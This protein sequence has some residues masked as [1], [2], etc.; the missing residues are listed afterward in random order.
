MELQVQ[1]A[2]A[3]CEKATKPSFGGME[4]IKEDYILSEIKFLHK[5]QMITKIE[6]RKK[7][8]LFFWWKYLDY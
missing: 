1:G 2:R 4:S 5:I 6:W 7:N 8:T 3:M